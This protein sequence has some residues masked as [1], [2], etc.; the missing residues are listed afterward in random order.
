MPIVIPPG[1]TVVVDDNVPGVFIDTPEYLPRIRNVDILENRVVFSNGRFVIPIM[2]NRRTLGRSPRKFDISIAANV[3]N[4]EFVRRIYQGGQVIG[5]ADSGGVSY[6]TYRFIRRTKMKYG[7]S[8][9]KRRKSNGLVLS[10]LST[11]FFVHTFVSEKIDYGKRFYCETVEPADTVREQ[12]RRN[13][14]QLFFDE[15]ISTGNGRVFQKYKKHVYVYTLSI[16]VENAPP[17]RCVR[18]ECLAR[19]R[20]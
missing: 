2:P 20:R 4:P 15:R 10:L 8:T 14:F 6:I 9:R 5:R 19:S 16:R 3:S 1:V 13:V 17:I 7:R 12:N 11:R 18:G